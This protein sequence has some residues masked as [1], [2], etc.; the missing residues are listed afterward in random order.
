MKKIIFF[1]LIINLFT[2]KANAELAFID[3][4][5]ILSDSIK[6]KKILKELSVQNDENNKIFEASEKKLE[7]KK[8][9][10]TKLKNI[11]SE[12]ELKNK[13]DQFQLEVKKYKEEKNKTIK[14]FE[15]L[16]KNELD[17]FFNSLNEILNTYM[18][19]NDISMVIEKK[20]IIM[21]NSTLDITKNILD[22]VNK[23]Q[24]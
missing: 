13:I 8:N 18:K 14:S 4:N 12:D 24:K 7:I 3:L 15:N 9:E 6:G 23:N 17:N 20:S 19:E 10:I 2:L 22:I 5:Y 11:I 21:A 1:F 16:K